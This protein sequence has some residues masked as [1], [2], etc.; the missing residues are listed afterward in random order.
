MVAG[1]LTP[2]LSEAVTS[3]PPSGVHPP[4]GG[5]LQPYQFLPE[6]P[7]FVSWKL[8]AQ[9]G[10]L[11]QNNRLVPQFSPEVLQLDG[12]SI[13]LQGFMMPLDIGDRQRRFLL[14]AAPPH[15]AFCLPAGPESMVEVRAKDPVRYTIDLVAIS[16]RLQVLREDP[17]GLYYRLVD[18]E[19]IRP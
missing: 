4:P 15:C 10:L 9:V 8:L 19:A 13:R 11:R 17:A 16:G 12:K 1:L 7:G 14:T 5:L 18:A 2:W 6:R 3:V